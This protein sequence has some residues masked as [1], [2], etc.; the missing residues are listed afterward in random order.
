M[1]LGEN[2]QFLRKKEN[3]TQEQLAERLDVSRQSIS[4]WESDTTWPEM[5]KLMQLSQMFHCTLDDLIQKDVSTLYG[6]DKYQY[7]KHMNL[8][9]KMISLG[10][11]LVLLGITIQM[12]LTTIG[13]HDDLCIIIMLLFIIIAVAIFVVMGL[14]HEDFKRK[15]PYI[16]N[17]YTEKE[18]DSFHKKFPVMIAVGIVLILTGVLITNTSNIISPEM[19]S[20]MPFDYDDILVSVMLLFVTIAVTIL[21]YAGLQHGKYNIDEYNKMHDEKSETYQLNQKKGSICACIMMASFIIYLILGFVFG[22][23]GMPSCVIFP[24]FGIGCG[25]VC[26]ILDMKQKK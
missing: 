1:S 22:E 10:V 13:I 15:N 23:W 2:L 11:S 8:F 16:E 21:V 6:E 14:Q 25:I 17:F 20:A 4:K 5:D 3:I 18:V 24:V 19:R 7:D 12:F 26:V 9:S